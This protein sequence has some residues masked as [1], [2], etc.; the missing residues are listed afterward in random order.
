MIFALN[1]PIN[2]HSIVNRAKFS[3]GN[4]YHIEN[5]LTLS[6][7]HGRVL[8]IIYDSPH[9][10][11]FLPNDFHSQV[12]RNS[13]RGCEDSFVHKL[14]KNATQN[15][16][17]FLQALF[18]RT[19]VDVNRASDDLDP[20]LYGPSDS[21]PKDANPS[22]KSH[23][24]HGVIWRQTIFQEPLYTSPLTTAEIEARLANYWQ[25]YHR[26]LAKLYDR[27]QTKFGGV[28]H[29]NCHSMP[30]QSVKNTGIDIV[31]GDAHGTSM[32]PDLKY[33]LLSL[34]TKQGLKVRMNHP[35]SGAF[36]IKNYAN[37]KKKLHALQIEINRA[38]Y[39]DESNLQINATF[40]ILQTT[41]NKIMQQIASYVCTNFKPTDQLR[42]NNES[43]NYQA[44]E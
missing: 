43:L 17:F 19:Y 24:G 38:L 32:A 3:G 11:T 14:F 22:E 1:Y 18:S 15:H 23:A 40:A 6:A 21:I 12:A 30:S 34:F 41:L 4:L 31:L 44:A 2:H 8:P 20:K 35:Y 5:I 29:F 33:F 25:P 26:T 16:A 9:S 42:G 13:I 27:L 7:P 10:G 28:F 39:M 36:L 37:P